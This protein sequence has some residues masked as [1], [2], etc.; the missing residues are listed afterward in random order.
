[1]VGVEVKEAESSVHVSVLRATS[2]ARLAPN[3]HFRTSLNFIGLEVAVVAVDELLC[4]ASLAKVVAVA[5]D[6]MQ[7]SGL[8]VSK[9]LPVE[10]SICRAVPLVDNPFNGLSVCKKIYI[11]Q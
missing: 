11:H 10:L 3:F 9:I 8:A 1:M 4:L 5:D 6:E 7:H 2:P